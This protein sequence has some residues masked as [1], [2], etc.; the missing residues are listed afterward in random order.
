MEDLPEVEPGAVEERRPDS[1]REFGGGDSGA[2]AVVVDEAAPG[3]EGA[4]A[5]VAAEV[6]IKEALDLLLELLLAN[7]DGCVVE[8]RGVELRRRRNMAADPDAGFELDGE[9]AAA[10]DGA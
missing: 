5:R 7:F 9:D 4:V 1:R 3:D 2:A 6:A 10:E 8:E